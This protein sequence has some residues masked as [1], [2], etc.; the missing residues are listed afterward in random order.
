VVVLRIK[1]EQ[2]EELQRQ[3]PSMQ[4]SIKMALDSYHLYHRVGPPWAGNEETFYLYA[5]KASVFL[6]LTL[7]VPVLLITL[8][9]FPMGLA[10]VFL[11]HSA[12]LQIGSLLLLLVSLGWAV[13]NGVDWSNDYYIV[14]NKRVVYI[15]KIVLM[16]DSRQEVPLDAILSTTVDSSAMGRAFGYG[17]VKV[18]TYTGDLVMPRIH[19]P[20]EVVSLINEKRVQAREA[21]FQQER[22]EIEAELRRRLNL[23]EETENQPVETEVEPGLVNNALANLFH[24][25]FEKDGIITYRTHWIILI[26]RTIL[27][28]LCILF[29]LALLMLR[30]TNSFIFIPVNI[31][32]ALVVLLEVGFFGWWLYQFVDWENDQ[33]IIGK[34]T[35]IDVTKK[36]LGRE[37]RQ[38]APFKNIQTVNYTRRNLIGLLFNYGMVVVKIG[39]SDFSFRNVYN[40]S[41]VQREIFNRFM[42]TMQAEKRQNE[43]R[44]REQIADYIE[45]YDKV[46]Q[47]RRPPLDS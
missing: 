8:I 4:P 31:V 26:K 46:R 19:H 43:I 1:S 45:I 7:A 28:G 18:S 37:E 21:S 41:Q 20:Y 22:K 36:P 13:W 40:P 33:Y 34:D 14:T 30:L 17:D 3:A 15:E 29:G 27:P 23:Q 38:T 9:V 16:Y 35:L 10:G 39:D 6:W 24:M 2:V 47:G 12:A 5:R 44:Q 42:D 11:Y 32:L 25:R